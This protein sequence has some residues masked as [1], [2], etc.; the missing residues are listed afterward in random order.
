MIGL[1]LIAALLAPPTLADGLRAIGAL[2]AIAPAEVVPPPNRLG[3]GL[4]L[5]ISGAAL[6]AGLVGTLAT[7]DCATKDEQARCV[8]LGSNPSVYASLVVLGL[9]GLTAGAWW[10]QRLP[11][12]QR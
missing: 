5:G 7:P 4:V 9:G 1:C 8:A 6:L 2:D 10:Y 12:D 11:V 3:P